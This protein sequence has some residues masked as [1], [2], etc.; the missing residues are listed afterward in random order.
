MECIWDVKQRRRRRRRRR[1]RSLRSYDK[2][3]VIYCV[4]YITM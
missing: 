2:C 4:V 3:I 1:R